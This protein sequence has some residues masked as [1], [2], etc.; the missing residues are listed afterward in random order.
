MA[1]SA[2]H[3]R[4]GDHMRGNLADKVTGH[5]L[6]DRGA[7][8]CYMVTRHEARLVRRGQAWRLEVRD[9][10]LEVDAGLA[11]VVKAILEREQFWITDLQGLANEPEDAMLGLLVELEKKGVIWR[12]AG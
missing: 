11:P 12:L 7:D 10:G 5:R 2:F 9:D 1:D 4:V 6:P 8:R 3:G